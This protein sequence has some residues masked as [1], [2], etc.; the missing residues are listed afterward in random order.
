MGDFEKLPERKK[1]SQYLLGNART[2]MIVFILFTVVVVMTA[3]IRLVTMSSI[4]DLGLE[5]FLLLFASYSMYICCADGGV[6]SGFAAQVYTSAVDRFNELKKR[7]ED[8]ML[9][10]MEEF[11]SYY[12]DEELRKERMQY[13]SV[14]CIPYDVYI[15]KYVNLSRKEINALPEL[16]D[17]Q[18]KAIKKANKVKRIKITPERI[19]TLGKASHTRSSLAITPDTMKNITYGTKLMKMILISVFV[20]MVALDVI[21]QPSW[22]VFAEVCLKLAAV[23]INGF[24]GR[25]DG[26]NNITVHTVNY[27][28]N[29]SSLMQQAIQYIEAHP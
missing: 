13:L 15:C 26:F 27:V 9:P 6:K 5:F 28:N 10:K 21:M 8:S 29:Q 14:V 7:I 2:L 20:P 19:M 24:A 16:K 22:T 11:C 18:K 23:V 3:D 25:N 4:T 12:V 1:L 17:S